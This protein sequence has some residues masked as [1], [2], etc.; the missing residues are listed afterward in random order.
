MISCI[1]SGGGAGAVLLL[2]NGQDS[3]ISG[4]TQSNVSVRV[5]DLGTVDR[6]RSGVFR[7]IDTF[8]NAMSAEVTLNVQCKRNCH[9]DHTAFRLHNLHEQIAQHAFL[10]QGPPPSA[11]VLRLVQCSSTSKGAVKW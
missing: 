1:T 6:S 7:C 4:V 3:V 2:E 9:R 10:L 5:F 8:D 11:S